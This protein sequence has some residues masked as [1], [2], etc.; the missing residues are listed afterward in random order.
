M[1]KHCV[2][3]EYGADY[4]PDDVASHP[5]WNR[6]SEQLEWYDTKSVKCQKRYK[7]IKVVQTVT[8]VSIPVVSQI[9]YDFAKWVTACAG[10]AI[11]L[12]ETL[13]QMNQYSTLWVIYRS[14]AERLK[15][16]K[17]IFVSGAGQ[18]K[19]LELNERLEILADRVEEHV[20]TEHAKWVDVSGRRHNDH[21]GANS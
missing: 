14:T 9:P 1:G 4:I 6:L 12:L 19:G 7:Y 16:E 20:S 8:A 5:A 10:A 3:H 13:Q 11:A 17:Y 18:Y 2:V 15:H 21:K